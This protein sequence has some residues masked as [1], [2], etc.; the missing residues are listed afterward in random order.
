MDRLEHRRVA[1]FRV[2]VAG[3]RNAQATGQCG[4]QIAKNIGVQIGRNNRV[5]RRRPVDHARGRRVHQ[6]LVPGDIGKLLGDLHCDLV[7]HHHCVALRVALGDHRQQLARPRLR[8]FEREAHDPLN[9]G[10]GHHR[11]IGS[12]FY[13]MALMDPAADTRVFTF[14]VFAHDDPIQI[15]SAT[16][17][18]WAVDARQDSG[19][20]HVGVLIK[21]LA[22]LQ[23]QSPQR[24]VVGNVRIA[25]RA[26]QDRV[27]VAQCIQ[28]RSRHHHAMFAVVIT[29][30]I[31]ILELEAKGTAGCG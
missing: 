30:P 9:A 18:Q 17:L 20:T 26:E 6:F 10:A 5:K 11:H 7:P 3:R 12:R 2:D 27:L 1:P 15:V 13:R 23:T 31:E 22:D 8:Q 21:S 29:A 4:R 16:A 19:R 14:R 24:N 25:G 28:A